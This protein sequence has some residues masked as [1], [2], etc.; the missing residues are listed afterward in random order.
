MKSKHI[1][2]QR[3]VTFILAEILTDQFQIYSISNYGRLFGSSRKRLC[4]FY[5][6]VTT[7]AKCTATPASSMYITKT[8]LLAAAAQGLAF[9]NGN[10]MLCDNANAFILPKFIS[11]LIQLY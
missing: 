6:Y 8:I 9:R 2:I 7:I 4:P 5:F 1:Y 3:Q 11:L 10:Y